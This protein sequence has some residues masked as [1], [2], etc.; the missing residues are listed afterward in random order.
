MPYEIREATVAGMGLGLFTKEKI[1]MG[2]LIWSPAGI[3]SFSEAEAK[4]YIAS[5]DQKDGK[6]LGTYCYWW[7][8]R[9]IDLRNDDGRFTNHSKSPN[10]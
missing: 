10:V 3:K 8:G 5:L 1:P 2:Q 7:A 6:E 4:D 9:L